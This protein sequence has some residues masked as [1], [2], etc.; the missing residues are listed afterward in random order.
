MLL[1]LVVVQMGLLGARH[2]AVT[3]VFVSAAVW[4]VRVVPFR[5]VEAVVPLAVDVDKAGAVLGA[6]RH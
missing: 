4:N 2:A 5:T 3:L 1:L 6:E